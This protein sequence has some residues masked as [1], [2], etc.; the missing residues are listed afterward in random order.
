MN[1]SFDR[2][3]QPKMVQRVANFTLEAMVYLSKNEF[4]RPERERKLGVLVVY[5][6]LTDEYTHSIFH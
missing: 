2:Y 3:G 6:N 5:H 1:N 4:T